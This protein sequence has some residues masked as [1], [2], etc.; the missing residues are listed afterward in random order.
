[1]N[2]IQGGPIQHVRWATIELYVRTTII[3]DDF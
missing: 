1:M 2:E 3:S